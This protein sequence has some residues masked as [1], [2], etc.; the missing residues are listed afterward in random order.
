MSLSN[1]IPTSGVPLNH[2]ASD[3]RSLSLAAFEAKYARAFFIR[4]GSWLTTPRAPMQTKPEGW[5][6]NAESTGEIVIMALPVRKQPLSEHPFVGIGRLEGCDI[7]I[8]DETVSKFH[9]YVKEQPE[10]TW[11]LQDAKSRNGTTV[12]GVAVAQ[13]G[14]GPPTPLKF[15]QVVRFGSVTTT[16]IDASSVVSLASRLARS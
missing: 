10:R 9:A 12:E 8:F 15:G 2:L 3:A 16:F 14:A 5:E 7:A 4:H 6:S 11:L 13:R 1:P